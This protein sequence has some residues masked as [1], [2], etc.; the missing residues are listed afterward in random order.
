M[1]LLLIRLW[2]LITNWNRVKVD[3][4][5]THTNIFWSSP[6]C[7]PYLRSPL[8]R[9]AIEIPLLSTS[10]LAFSF[11]WLCFTRPLLA[12]YINWHWNYLH[13]QLLLPT[14]CQKTA[15]TKR[16]QRL[17]RYVYRYELNMQLDN[18]FNWATLILTHFIWALEVNIQLKINK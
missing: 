17:F 1:L 4:H 16:K 15:S 13:G 5:S 14:K 6:S 10:T 11:T 3:T 8:L 7:F 12:I 18:N 9:L 2:C